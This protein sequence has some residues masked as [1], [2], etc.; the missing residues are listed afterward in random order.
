MRRLVYIAL[1]GLLWTVAFGGLVNALDHLLG[2]GR[3]DALAGWIVYGAGYWLGLTTVLLTEEV[4][5]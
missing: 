2:G 1:L 4:Q 5:P 3:S